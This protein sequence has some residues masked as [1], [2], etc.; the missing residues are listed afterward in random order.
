MHASVRT[1]LPAVCKRFEG[2][3]STMFLDTKGLVTTGTGNL[4]DTVK[5]A[6]ALPWLTKDNKPASNAQVQAE[7]KQIK[8]RQSIKG[9]GGYAYVKYATL[10][11]AE[12]TIDKLL[13]NKTDEFWSTLSRTVKDVESF[14]A[15]AQLALLDLAWQNGPAFLSTWNDTRKSVLAMDF[16]NTTVLTSSLK[17][18]PRTTFR[19]RLF[20]NAATVLRLDL[21]VWVPVGHQDPGVPSRA[22]PSASCD[23][24]TYP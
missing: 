24:F 1:A 6:Q 23:P 19:V 5:A 20:K 17:A 13:F 12:P 11:L 2:R 9:L 3:L 8:A 15:D 14:P 21:D 22:A 10:H 18:S 4:I 16:A 7:W